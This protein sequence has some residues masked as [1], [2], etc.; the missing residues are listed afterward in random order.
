MRPSDALYKVLGERIRAARE[1]SSGRLS[2]ASL[3]K[4]LGVSRASIVNIEA[5]RQ[6]A[7]LGLLWEIA[8]ALDTELA[9]LIPQRA[10][11]ED[12]AADAVLNDS[13]LK[14]IKMKA[15]GDESMERDLTSFVAQ[16][17]VAANSQKSSSEGTQ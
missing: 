17:L 9:L 10:E 14:Q 13:M 1:R 4:Q 7:P 5:G 3:A 6:H 11:L 2:Q 15:G 16:L 12:A 8:H